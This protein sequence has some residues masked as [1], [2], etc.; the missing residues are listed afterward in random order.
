MRAGNAS[1]AAIK[2]KWAELATEWHYIA[3][4]AAQTEGKSSLI[5]FERSNLLACFS[6]QLTAR[7]RAPLGRW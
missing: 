4:V 5:A 2:R 6:S 1:D 7:Q 3:N